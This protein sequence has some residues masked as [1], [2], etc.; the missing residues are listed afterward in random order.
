M[1]NSADFRYIARQALTGRWGIAIGAGLLASLMG[2]GS[3]GGS[4]DF[5]DFDQSN[6]IKDSV[7]AS[8]E[9]LSEQEL[10]IIAIIVLTFLSVIFV[11]SLV[12]LFLGS[13][14]GIGYSKFNLDLV[15][16]Q[17][18]PRI[19]SLFSYFRF[20]KT[21]ICTSL[22]KGL[23]VF[24]WS[25]LFIIPGIIASYSYALTDYIL[26]EN[27]TLTASQAIEQSKILMKGNRFRYFCLELSFF[28]WAVLCVLTFGVGLI[29]FIPYMQAAFAAFYRDVSG[30]AYY[31][32][33]TEAY[34]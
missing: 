30:A 11:L 26:A 10:T 24:L 22:L 13:I 8:L 19:V 28:G 33:Q 27:P 14:V 9:K 1:K 3:S 25:L 23:Y 34:C 18:Q 7:T 2:V 21:A 6:S 20:W 15:D 16:G 17:F 32:Y 29:W 31:N 4:V 12:K 5:S